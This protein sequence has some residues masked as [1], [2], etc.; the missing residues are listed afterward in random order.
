LISNGFQKLLS[1]THDTLVFALS[2]LSTP[3][4]I[5][6][7]AAGFGSQWFQNNGTDEEYDG[8]GRS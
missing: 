3:V 6:S 1:R 8:R 7:H 4:L 5:E 2:P